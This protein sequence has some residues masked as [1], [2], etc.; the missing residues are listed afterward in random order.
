MKTISKLLAAACALLLGLPLV[1]A[2][3]FPAYMHAVEQHNAAYLAE[4]YQVDIAEAQTRAAHVFNDPELSVS[5]GNNQDWSLQMGQSVETGLAYSFSLGNVRR[6]RIN[7]ARSEEDLTR[8]ALDDWFRNLKA[9][10]TL[11]W[12]LAQEARAL[13]EIKRSTYEG[14]LQVAE[15]DS[16]RAVLGDGSQV[17]ARQ[18]RIEARALRADYLAAEAEYANALNTLSLYAGGMPVR[19]VPD[20]DIAIGVPACPPQEM[21]ELALEHRADL[22]AA[23]LSRTLS[24][25]NLAL[26]KASRAPELELSAGYSY[27]TEV[28]NEIAPAPQY[29]G[30]SVGVAV[31]LKFSRLNR[32]ERL[33]A[34]RSVQQ[35]EAAYEAAQQQIV[36]EVQQAFVSWQAAVRV[37]QECSATMLEDAASILESRRMAYLQGDSSLLDYLMAVRVYNETAEQCIA[38]RTG[39][40]AAAAELL[41]AIGL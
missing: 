2:Q 8:A 31:P 40:S 27:N 29:H 39:L 13:L 19:E 6:A 17:D 7:V 26:V 37:A 11:A 35:A 25:R 18:S 23:E 24:E 15:S 32:G 30:L 28:R 1:R 3:G 22:R 10:A 4:R 41:Q 33:A 9:E 20:M 14:M 38:A 34:E 36:A 5:Y 12:I 16:L 21:V